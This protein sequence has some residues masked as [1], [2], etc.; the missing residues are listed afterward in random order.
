MPPRTHDLVAPYLSGFVALLWHPTPRCLAHTEGRF[1]EV[2]R[3]REELGEAAFLGLPG[4]HLALESGNHGSGVAA[5]GLIWYATG[6]S[7]S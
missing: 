2:P 3:A 6:R 1:E 4:S 5:F 7:C